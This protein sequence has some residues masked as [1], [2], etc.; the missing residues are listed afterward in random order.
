MGAIAANEEL[1]SIFDPAH[2]QAVYHGGSF[3][4]N[5]LGTTAGRV[6][7]EHFGSHEIERMNVQGAR[8]REALEKASRVSGVPL[9]V[10]GDGSI[11]GVHVLGAD[12]ETSHT[13]SRR[14]HLAAINRGVYFGQDGEFALATPFTDDDVSEAI[15]ILGL[16]LADLAPELETEGA[17]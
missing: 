14:F 16:A 5:P 12:G 2:P 10:T 7:M 8:L 1:M 13:L 6:A 17:S 11:L 3:N 9:D 15:E 4:G